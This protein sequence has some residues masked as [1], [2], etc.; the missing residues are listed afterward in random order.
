VEHPERQER[1]AIDAA[2]ATGETRSVHRPFVR[3]PGKPVVIGEQKDYSKSTHNS[4]PPIMAVWERRRE[5]S[6]ARAL[7]S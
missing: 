1:V 7:R 4:L 5:K 3:E 6:T 2:I